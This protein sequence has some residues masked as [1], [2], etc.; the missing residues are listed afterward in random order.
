MVELARPSRP[1]QHPALQSCIVP[2]RL[3]AGI[4]EAGRGCLAGPVVAAA[5]ILPPG[6][7]HPLLNDSKQ[8]SEKTRD[9]LR[10]DIELK[11]LAWA[12]ASA[13]PG[14]IDELN[15]L[16]ATFLAMNQAIKALSTVPEHLLIDGNR[17]LNQTGIA[18][19]CVV[20]G[21]AT[22]MSIAAAS[23]LAKTHRDELMLSLNQQY[24]LYCWNKNKGYPTDFHRKAIV[25]YGIS[26]WHRKSF[27]L[28]ESQLQLW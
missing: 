11:A 7:D 22:F 8:L 14:E 19:T 12:V 18:Y 21:D 27:R 3:E 4:D 24:P 5:V 10:A 13:S 6:Y 16:K 23:V 26:P 1:S 17:F 15:I 2:G 28:T 9:L 20:K 25:Q